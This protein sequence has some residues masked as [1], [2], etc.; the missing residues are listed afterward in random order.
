MYISSKK[1][2]E[3]NPSGSTAQAIKN[4]ITRSFEGLIN[5]FTSTE[6]TWPVKRTMDRIAGY[7]RGYGCTL[8]IN[9]I[10]DQVLKCRFGGNGIPKRVASTAAKYQLLEDTVSAVDWTL[11]SAMRVALG[12]EEIKESA[13]NSPSY[14]PK[15][16]LV[17]NAYAEIASMVRTVIKDKVK[18]KGMKVLEEIDS[19]GKIT[20]YRDVMTPV[21]TVVSWAVSSDDGYN[22]LLKI[23]RS[24]AGGETSTTIPLGGYQRG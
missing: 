11:E 21:P 18:R 15:D 12:R 16:S 13:G 19:T 17:G 22:D 14:A 9:E 23:S 6:Y 5:M 3:Y 7:L 24:N 10:V 2:Y 8:S 20:I 1:W 4:A